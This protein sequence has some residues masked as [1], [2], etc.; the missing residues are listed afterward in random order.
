MTV[1]TKAYGTIEVAE[2]QR[3]RFPSGLYGFDSHT[4]F[5]LMDSAQPPL[6][7]LQSEH[8]VSVAFILINPYVVRPDYVLDIPPEDLDELGNPSEDDILVFSIITIP[9]SGE[10]T[11]NLQGPL[12]LNRARRIGKQ[13]ISLDSRWNTKHSIANEMARNR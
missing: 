2:E 8:D 13:S 9:A 4:N 3:I 5:V 12:V 11:A 1:A 10:I 7:W 6:Y